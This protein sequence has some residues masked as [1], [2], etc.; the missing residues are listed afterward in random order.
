[1]SADT[2]KRF[3]RFKAEYVKNKSNKLKAKSVL[4]KDFGGTY[5]YYYL[6]AD[7]PGSV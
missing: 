1:M 4:A 5:W 7:L 3:N 2:F 6:F